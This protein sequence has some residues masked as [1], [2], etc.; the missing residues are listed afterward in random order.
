MIINSFLGIHNQNHPRSI[1]DNALSDAVNVDIDNA[2]AILQRKGYELSQSITNVT[3][4]YSTVN[5]EGYVVASGTLYRVKDDL[6]LISLAPSTATQFSDINGILFTNDGLKVDSDNVVDIKIPAP[7][8]PPDI[9]ITSG[10]LS[11]GTYSACY[12]FKTASGIEGGS[13]PIATIELTNIGGITINLV[14]PPSCLS[15]NYY[16]TDCNGTVYYDANGAQLNPVQILAESYPD[17]VEIIA[18]HESRLWISKALPNKSSIIWFS[19]PFHYHL[20]NLQADY[21]IVPGNIR[22]MVSS[23]DALIIATDDGIYAYNDSLVK[24]ADYGVTKGRSMVKTSANE[25]MIFTKRGVCVGMPFRN[26]T[27]KKAS[28]PPGEQCSTALVEESGMRKFV[29]LSDGSGDPYN[30]R[31]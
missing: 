25:V 2:G 15:V 28:F 21:I 8:I 1:P 31:F 24:L 6:S 30:S 22:A 12:C 17:N 10:N 4:A 20:Y 7:E 27:D 16:L 26:I 29:A 14:A 3:S 13:S 5:Q 9:T 11:A 19:A 23:G 18:W